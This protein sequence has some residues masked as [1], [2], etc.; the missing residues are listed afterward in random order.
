MS[1]PCARCG[2]T[3]RYK[4]G[5]CS[6]C[7]KERERARYQNNRQEIDAKHTAWRKANP[8]KHNAASARWAKENPD[9]QRARVLRWKLENKERT[10]ANLAAWHL[11]NKERRRVANALWIKNNPEYAAA[12]TSQRKAAALQATP[13]W[14]NEFFVKEAY[15]LAKLRTK[16]FGFKWHV[17]HIVPL[18]SDRVCGLHVEH[19]LQVIPGASNLAKSNRFWPHQP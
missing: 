3:A 5:D 12:K 4:S 13:S 17:D 9:K 15:A 18:N 8:D 6:T 16:I 14:A 1:K 10:A 19:N 7:A 11:K 2:G